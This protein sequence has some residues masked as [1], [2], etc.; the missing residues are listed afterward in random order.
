MLQE[1]IPCCD[2]LG[3]F[4][5]VHLLHG[6]TEFVSLKINKHVYENGR[7]SEHD[8]CGKIHELFMNIIV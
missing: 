1:R 3:P 6:E 5:C 7:I 4:I 2:W 8:L